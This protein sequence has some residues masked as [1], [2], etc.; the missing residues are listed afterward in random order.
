MPHT[1][2]LIE[3]I[4]NV[5]NVYIHTQKNPPMRKEH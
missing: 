1:Q 3:E 5:A 2:F 4:S